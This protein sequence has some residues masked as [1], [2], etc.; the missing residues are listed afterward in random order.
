MKFQ[1][2]EFAD[3]LLIEPTVFNDERGC[4]FESYNKLTFQSNGVQAE[5]VQ[6][7]LSVSHKNV[8]RGLHFQSPPFAQGKLV[9]VVKGSV[10]DVVVDIRKASLTYGKSYSVELTAANNIMLYVPPGFAHG[11]ISLEDNTVFT[12]KCTNNYNKASE[13]GILWNDPIL[14]IDWKCN[15]SI[16]SEKD[17]LLPPF[18]DLKS[19][20]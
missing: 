14:N 4:F 7:N 18:T 17:L 13:G 2:T 3:L 10:L 6:D 19:Q 12:Y 11:F 20:F 16:L 9:S 8:L 5:F 15:S 1:K